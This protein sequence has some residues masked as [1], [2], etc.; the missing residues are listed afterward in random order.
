MLFRSIGLALEPQDIDEVVL[1]FE[2]KDTTEEAMELLLPSQ[3]RASAVIAHSPSLSEFAYL[4]AVRQIPQYTIRSQA[5]F[6]R[7]A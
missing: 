6:C 3:R 1:D 5:D 4:R 7:I 2:V